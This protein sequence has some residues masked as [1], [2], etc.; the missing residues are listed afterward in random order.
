MRNSISVTHLDKQGYIEVHS[1]GEKNIDSARQLWEQVSTLADEVNCFKVLGVA[2]TD[3]NHSTIEGYKHAELFQDIGIDYKYKIA[4]V[5]KNPDVYNDVK[6]IETVLMNRGTNI[7]L[8]PDQAEAR[9][10]LLK[11]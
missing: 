8:F 10:W 2:F 4:W 11:D 9:S 3:K 7:K 1:D 6:F 5:E